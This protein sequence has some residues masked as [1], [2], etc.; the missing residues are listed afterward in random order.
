MVGLWVAENEEWL[1]L[2][3]IPVDYVVDGYVLVVKQHIVSRKPQR[4]RKQLEQ[5][6]R[7]KGI[8]AEAPPGFVFPETIEMLRWVEQRYG[9]VEFTDKEQ[10]T[11]LGWVRAADAVH[12]WFDSLSPDGTLFLDKD[13]L[14]VIS[15]IQLICLD[16]DY[17]NS[18]KLLWQH[19][20][21]QKLLKPSDN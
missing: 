16:A 21:R 3:C 20:S 5:V 17:F 19:K 4:G 2:R 14:F 8:K 7:L 12:L 6:L 15:E 18:L 13:D 9:L 1:L 11:F 10:C